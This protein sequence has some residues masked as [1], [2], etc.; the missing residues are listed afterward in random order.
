VD[1]LTSDEM[2]PGTVSLPHG[3]GHHR[4]GSRL[5]VA[6]AHAGVS[7]NDVTDEQ[8][9]DALCGNAALNGVPV[10]LLPIA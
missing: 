8:K 9:L 10:E 2:M 1:V 4:S 7:V 6:A 3:Y 5:R